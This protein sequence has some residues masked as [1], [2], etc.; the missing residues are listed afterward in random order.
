MSRDNQWLIAA[1]IIIFYGFIVL[2]SISRRVAALVIL[3]QLDPAFLRLRRRMELV[4]WISLLYGVGGI[5]AYCM[6]APFKPELWA[7]VVVWVLMATGLCK[8]GLQAQRSAR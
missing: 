3:K 5:L 4:R 8:S 1:A 7:F 2:W 6:R